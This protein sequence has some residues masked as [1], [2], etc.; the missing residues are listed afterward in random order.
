MRILHVSSTS[1]I[2]GANRYAFDLAAGQ[3]DLG[4]SPIVAMPKTPA[5]ALD[6]SRPDVQVILFGGVLALSFLEVVRRTKPDILHCHDGTTTRWIRPL[7]FRPPTMTTLHIRYK[8][9]TMG[10]MDGVHMIADWQRDALTDFRGAVTKIGNW[11]PSLPVPSTEEVLQSR[12]QGGAGDRDFLVVFVGRLETVK[13]VD[14]LLDAFQR[15]THAGARL[16]I[17]GEGPEEQPLRRQAAGDLRITFAGA[18]RNPAQWYRAADLVVLPSRHEPFGLVAVEAMMHH[19]PILASRIEGL[20]EIFA[21]RPDCL[22]EAGNPETLA[23]QISGRISRKCTADIMRDSY[24]LTPFDRTK[25]VEN[26]TRFY[27]SVIAYRKNGSV[28]SE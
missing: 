13:G 5:R 27:D 23:G 24:D 2:S 26:I 28:A 10:H 8:S 14:I 16:V 3:I 11:I 15:I 7:P 4:H 9:K 12:A 25:G 20:A 6:F 1:T 21:G 22:T 18:S 17:V 19:A